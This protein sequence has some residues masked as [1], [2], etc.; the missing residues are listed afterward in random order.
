MPDKISYLIGRPLTAF[1]F[2]HDY[3]Q[4]QFDG[5]ILTANSPVQVRV[6]EGTFGKNDDRFSN[7]VRSIIGDLVHRATTFIDERIL[8]EFYKGSEISISLK[9]E[10]QVGPEAAVLTGVGNEI[11]VW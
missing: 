5:P 7:I 6:T 4:F 8:L 2:V 10:D 11:C 3:M 1:T 9:P